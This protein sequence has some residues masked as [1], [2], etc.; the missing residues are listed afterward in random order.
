MGP[1]HA[2]RAENRFVRSISQNPRPVPQKPTEGWPI[3]RAAKE[4]APSVAVS[5]GGDQL[6]WSPA[7]YWAA[8]GETS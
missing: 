1:A 8:R 2:F 5:V 4:A 6:A 3:L 7:L